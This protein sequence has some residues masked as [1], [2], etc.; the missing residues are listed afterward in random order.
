[1]PINKSGSRSWNN[2]RESRVSRRSRSSRG[3][4]RSRGSRG[5]RRSRRSRRLRSSTDFKRE[6]ELKKIDEARRRTER[7]PCPPGQILRKGYRRSSYERTDRLGRITVS[8]AIVPPVCIRDVGQPDYGPE[9]GP[10]LIPHLLGQFGYSADASQGKRRRALNNAIENL[11]LDD[12]YRHLRNIVTLQMR[13]PKTYD[14]MLEDFNYLRRKYYPRR[15]D[16]YE[17]VGF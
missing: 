1:M 15:I 3:L 16:V 5:S 4:R 2:S 17:A 14:I 11:G 6:L 10:P 12:V 9:V 7:N 13:N 8:E